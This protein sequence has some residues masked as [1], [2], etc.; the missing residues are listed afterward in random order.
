MK[1]LIISS[2]HN[3]KQISYSFAST[4]AAKFEKN[5]F[6]TEICEL[7]KFDINSC[8]ATGECGNNEKRRCIKT[9]DDFNHLCDKIND[10]DALLLIIPKY[11]PYPSKLIALLE[12]ISALS[13]W[14][15]GIKGDIKEFNLISKPIANLAFV[16]VPDTPRNIFNPLFDN[17]YQI[18]FDTVTFDGRNGLFINRR[19]DNVE[20]QLDL[21]ARKMMVKLAE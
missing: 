4:L 14:A 2:S 8:C 16:H 15:Y 19:D 11:T 9:E 10:S 18:G 20:D 17:I 7:A 13:W 3:S 6:Q 12:R 5:S 21:V 1:I